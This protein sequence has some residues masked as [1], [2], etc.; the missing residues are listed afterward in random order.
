MISD[1]TRTVSARQPGNR[2]HSGSEAHGSTVIPQALFMIQLS[3]SD[4]AATRP[5]RAS[6]YGHVVPR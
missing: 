4:A 5:G 2:R 1:R 6:V 3:E